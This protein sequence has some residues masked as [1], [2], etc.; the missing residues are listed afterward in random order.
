VFFVANPAFFIFFLCQICSI[1]V[2][3]GQAVFLFPRSVLNSLLWFCLAIGSATADYAPLERCVPADAMAAYF[4]RPSPEMLDAP[5][6]GTADNLASWFITL[7]GMGVIPKDGRVAADIIGSV[8]ILWRRP[9]AIMLLDVSS[10]E[11]RPNVYRLAQMQAAMI[12]ANKGIELAI[13][14]RIRDLLA[15]YTDGDNGKIAVRAVDDIAINRLTDLRLPDWAVIEWGQ[16]GD[17]FVASLGQGAFDRVLEV[18]KGRKPSLA[19][20]DWFA[21]AHAR[22]RGSESGLEIY[23][24]LERIRARL[25]PDTKDR[26]AAVLQALHLQL[27]SRVIWTTGHDERAVRSLVVGRAR[28]GEDVFI[29]LSA[30]EN[31]APEVAAVIPAE[32]SSYFVLRAPLG[33]L[34]RTFRNGYM[35]SQSAGQQRAVHELW[36]RLQQQYDFDSET[37]VLD[38]LG[39]HFIVHT[40]P[41]HPLDLPLFW[42]MWIQIKGDGATVNRA[43]DR[44]MTAWK[45]ELSRPDP[46]LPEPLTRKAIASGAA[47]RPAKRK[48]AFRLS[49]QVRHEP[50]GLWSLQLG[51]INPALAVTKD[52]MIIS[53]SPESVR[54]NLRH[55]NLAP[56]TATAPGE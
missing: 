10:Q 49:P 56:A 31:A 17:Y 47:T 3:C 12:V 45:E 43:V 37:Q 5:P 9:H 30:R 46:P 34:F 4:G 24:D 25:E 8:P 7:K 22:A 27:A 50:D 18:L 40:W 33:D 16:V 2:I 11:V 13:D 53:W 42:T 32:A 51:F 55:L 15:T 48:P 1:R 14:R 20:D 36:A 41:P 44:M 35:E 21:Q 19:G 6:G 54:A 28:N 52:W 38:Q 39:D 29:R 26:P 23:G